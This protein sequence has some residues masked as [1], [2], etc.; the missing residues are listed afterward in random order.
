MSI[1]TFSVQVPGKLLLSGEY[2]ILEPGI[3]G[4]GLAVNRYLTVNFSPSDDYALIS[5]LNPQPF[6]YQP[7]S[8]ASTQAPPELSFAVSALKWGWDYLSLQEQDLAPFHLQISSELHQGDLKLGLGSSAAVCVGVIAAILAASGLNLT[9]ANSRKTLYQLAYLAHFAV[10]G[11]GSGM[12]IASCIYGSVTAYC[13]PDL[14]RL[15]ATDLKQSL[16]LDWPLLTL[17]SLFWPWQSLQFAWT[18]QKAETRDLIE[19]YQAW[20]QE[21]PDEHSHFLFESHANNLG[22]HQA[23]KDQNLAAFVSGLARCRRIMQTISQDWPTQTETTELA[24]LADIAESL[25]GAGKFSGAGG[26]DCGLAWVPDD[27]VETLHQKW[28]EACLKPLELELDRIGVR[29]HVAD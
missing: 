8:L 2:A 29:I 26:G 4:L 27:Q 1:K 17:E 25:G 15:P 9:E 22:L 10:Q 12:D 19:D 24:A 7:Q 23:L 3:L 6:I 13:S 21:Y 18:G 28:R 20:C 5:D 14:K 11:S 16:K